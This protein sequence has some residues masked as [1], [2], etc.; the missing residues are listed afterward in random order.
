MKIKLLT[1]DQDTTTTLLLSSGN[2][3]PKSTDQQESS[4]KYSVQPSTTCPREMISTQ[5]V[6]TLDQATTLLRKELFLSTWTIKLHRVMGSFAWFKTVTCKSGLSPTRLINSSDST[7]LRLPK[8]PITSVLVVT[9]LP[10]QWRWV[11]VRDSPREKRFQ[12]TRSRKHWGKA[13]PSGL[14]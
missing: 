6:I 5:P 14:S 13:L 4:W 2:P 10:L 3:N 8:S 9:T 1:S 12:P 7:M 11:A